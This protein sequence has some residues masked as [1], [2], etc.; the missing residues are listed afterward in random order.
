M[1]WYCKKAGVADENLDTY[2]LRQNLI[3]EAN[4]SID[5]FAQTLNAAKVPTATDGGKSF[6]KK[7][8]E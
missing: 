7:L 3:N 8:T 6:L 1:R 4:I 5:V 2:L